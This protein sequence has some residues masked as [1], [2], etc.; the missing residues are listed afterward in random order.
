MKPETEKDKKEI[1]DKSKVKDIKQ[2]R[3][4]WCFKRKTDEKII[5]TLLPDNVDEKESL[6]LSDEESDTDYIHGKPTRAEDSDYYSS[7]AST[8]YSYS[9]QHE[10]TKYDNVPQTPRPFKDIEKQEIPDY[11]SMESFREEFEDAQKKSKGTS[12]SKTKLD[13][14][15]LGKRVDFKEIPTTDSKEV[16]QKVTS[17]KKTRSKRGLAKP[18]DHIDETDIESEEELKE[19]TPL[20]ETRLKQKKSKHVDFM[21]IL[22]GTK[23]KTKL[24]SKG[25]GKKKKGKYA[26]VSDTESEPEFIE[27]RLKEKEP[28]PKP[29]LK[30][31]ETKST[32]EDVDNVYKKDSMIETKEKQKEPSEK[33]KLTPIDP[34][35]CLCSESDEEIQNLTPALSESLFS[36][37][38]KNLTEANI[39]KNDQNKVSKHDEIPS[40]LQI[41]DIPTLSE[42][43]TCKKSSDRFSHVRYD[44]INESPRL[45][46]QLTSSSY[47]SS[48]SDCNSEQYMIQQKNPKP[49][50]S[51]RKGPVVGCADYDTFPTRRERELKQRNK[52]RQYYKAVKDIPMKKIRDISKP[53]RIRAVVEKIILKVCNRLC[54][55]SSRFALHQQ[56]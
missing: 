34:A 30:F 26:E 27:A 20:I 4:W 5:D 51:K 38:E 40:N 18:V 39:D 16:R 3:R 14:S 47:I 2:P 19:E 49:K 6:K 54:S 52:I 36:L 55:I 42:I 43:C 45:S 32:V 24:K 28:K 22:R 7:D 50:A 1:A 29:L 25:K 56:F 48:I 12:I 13:T 44:E 10:K 21:G 17:K 8:D 46:N 9:Y 41:Q 15:E 33:L 37:P 35:I 11:A 53:S 31:E 23:E